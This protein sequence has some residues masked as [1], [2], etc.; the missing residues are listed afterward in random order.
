MTAT[1]TDLKEIEV[2]DSPFVKKEESP[3][4]L[5][6]ISEN[7]IARNPGGNRDI[8]KVIQSFPGVASTVT[9]RNDIIIRGG[10]PNENKFYLDDIETP[11]INHFATQGASG[12]P[13]GMINVD[14]IRE[15]LF[16][17]SSFPAEKSN[18][19]SSVMD[20]NLK[21]GRTDK[22]GGK[23]TL[24]AS[25][26]GITAEGPANNNASF[27]FSARR[28]YLQFLF[29]ALGLP[30]L[31]TYNDFLLKYKWKLGSKDEISFIGLGAIDVSTLNTKLQENGT[32]SQKFILG[33]LPSQRQWNYT[34]G[35]RYIHYR[36]NSY[37][38]IVLSRNMLDNQA[39]KYMNNIT[40]AEN[41]LLDYH[42][43]EIENKVRVENNAVI[44]GFKLNA[45]ANI[46]YFKYNNR[47]FNKQTIR[48]SV[49]TVNYNSALDGFEWGL[50]A[51]ASKSFFYKRFSI[52]FGVRTDGNNFDKAMSQTFRQLSPRISFSYSLTPFTTL[53]LNYGRFYQVPPY[54][55]IGF[56]NN[57][58][59]LVNK[60]TNVEYMRSQH[61]V[62]GFDYISK[63]NLKL[64]FETFYK[65]YD[66]YPFAVNEGISLANLGSD[67]GVVGN[68]EV[69]STSVGRAY[70]FE[71]LAQQKLF[72][73]FYGLMTY[74]FVRS[75][76][77]DVNDKF[78]SSSW[79]SRNIFNLIAGK[80]FNHD[81]EIGIKWKYSIGMP[82]TPYN[83]NATRLIANWD[84]N[85]Q[86]IY[87]WSRLNSQRM[88]SYQELDLRI[89]KKY[90][91]RK[92]TYNFYVDIQN[93]YNYKVKLPSYINVI[94]D[95][96]GNP[97]V[98]P[99][100]HTRYLAKYIN[101]FAGSILPTIGIILEF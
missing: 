60:N 81:W 63:N 22:I 97:V 49:V 38:K 23:F 11:N 29:Q 72:K 58:G 61:L 3:L 62:A 67:F 25:D 15:V 16:Y 69:V 53:N 17:S 56:R 44:N 14:Y 86:G 57:N 100:D 71:I 68:E 77:R 26:I 59:E 54:T 50:F 43:Q 87:D 47:T 9:Y 82:Y 76:F 8:S 12:G 52:S 13:V 1:V 36:K 40:K 83:F 32:E 5:R 28:S 2:K 92:L 35:I 19:L 95:S 31:P 39:L 85:H 88:P 20:F 64:N 79:D 33:Y 27:I 21:D 51:Q 4:S 66:Q 42:S 37:T 98:D 18:A 93:L 74:T 94:Y 75:E 30:F 45:G 6:N 99:N 55:V 41:K 96:K 70:G 80:S 65:Y 91:R 84:V 90:Y 10:S 46:E 78:I 73:G 101:S 24:G 89:D 7:E 48:D 34:N